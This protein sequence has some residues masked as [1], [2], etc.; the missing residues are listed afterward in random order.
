MRIHNHWKGL[1]KVIGLICLL[2]FLWVYLLHEPSHFITCLTFG[3]KPHLLP[4]QINP[5]VVCQGAENFDSPQ[6]LLYV[7]MPYM[8]DIAAL[9]IFVFLARKSLWMKMLPH[10]AFFDLLSNFST[11]LFALGKNDF[12]LIMDFN[13]G[14]GI[15]L[16]AA[17]VMIWI[18]YYGSE[19]IDILRPK[20]E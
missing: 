6:L 4:A 16:V 19:L 20:Q 13:P 3:G 17:I 18:V 8:V 14:I 15:M 2:V 5:S 11:S 1:L 9:I 12:L 10:V 7:I